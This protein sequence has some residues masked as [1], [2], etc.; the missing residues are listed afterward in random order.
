MR[1]PRILFLT[2]WW[3]ADLSENAVVVDTA[4]ALRRIGPV[5]VVSG[6]PLNLRTNQ[7]TDGRS[8][9]RHERGKL[10]PFPYS[11]HSAF[12]GH[13]ASPLQRMAMY[14]TFAA[15]SLRSIPTAWSE[16]DVCVV[17][18]SP[19]TAATAGYFGKR[20]RGVPYICIVQDVWPDS[21]VAS[22]LLGNKLVERIAR[23]SL[24]LMTNEFYRGASKVVVISE[25]MRDL[26]ISRGVPVDKLAVIYNWSSEGVYTSPVSIPE[27]PPGAPLQIMYAGNFGPLQAL[28][29]VIRALAHLPPEDYSLTLVGGGSE[30]EPLRELVDALG[31][32]NVTFVGPR[33]L[34]AMPGV[35]AQAHVHL[36]SL[37]DDPLFEVTIP[38]KL[39][40][41]MLAG[42]PIVGCLAGEPRSII[43]RAGAGWV[44]SPGVPE[45]MAAMLANVAEESTEE[46]RER[47]DA[48]RTYYFREMSREVGELKLREVVE[49]VIATPTRTHAGTPSTG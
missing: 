35:L 42:V 26:L 44:T 18:S 25:G 4:H 43:E 8:W 37:R 2:Q 28:D 32:R 10:G 29:N 15:S 48:G 11:R 7:I 46:L 21:V 27:R 40:S 49:E 5:V 23:S 16:A 24:N 9:R 3:P 33:A 41:L 12:P 17:Y 30:E 38:G 1:D 47:G 13:S 20:L 6:P 14:T 34:E 22:G 36:V 39:Q 19:M 31:L 45:A